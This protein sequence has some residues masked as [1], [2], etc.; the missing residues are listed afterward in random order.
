M[1]IRGIAQGFE[2]FAETMRLQRLDLDSGLIGLRRHRWPSLSVNAIVTEKRKRADAR[3][4]LPQRRDVFRA[5]IRSLCDDILDVPGGERR[6]HAATA[7]DVLENGPGLF[8]H[9]LGQILDVPRAAGRIGDAAEMA[10]LLADDLDVARDAACE[11]IRLAERERE[12]Q[13][14]DRIGAAERRARARN[15]RA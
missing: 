15:R 10:F 7:F 3:Q 5:R 11:C 14:N 1:R 13:N 4:L 9:I 8:R 12:R 2:R 6:R